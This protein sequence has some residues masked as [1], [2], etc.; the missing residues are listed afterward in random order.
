MVPRKYYQHVKKDPDKIKSIWK[1]LHTTTFL[2]II[3]NSLLSAYIF[4]EIL[5]MFNYRCI[6]HGQPIFDV[7]EARYMNETQNELIDLKPIMKNNNELNETKVNIT[8]NIKEMTVKEGNNETRSNNG[9]E[10]LYLSIFNTSD[11]SVNVTNDI[12]ENLKHSYLFNE[13]IWYKND[14]LYGKVDVRIRGSD[15]GSSTSCDLILFVPL[16]SLI[17]AAAFGALIVL[18]GRG[19]E[20]DRSWLMVYPVLIA[21]VIMVILYIISTISMK[22]GLENFCSKFQHFTGYFTCSAYMGYF[23]FHNQES[24]RDFWSNYTICYY[25]YIT[26]IFLWST[27][28]AVTILRLATMADFQFVTVSVN[29]TD[30]NTNEVRREKI[31]KALK[32]SGLRPAADLF[33]SEED[34]FVSEEN[35]AYTHV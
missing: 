28:L 20:S 1:V 31:Q 13:T 12:T 35:V 24:I 4:G 30:I 32:S 33:P 16:V 2:V 7:V 21:S 8:E 17:A 9:P 26:S 5:K 6:L 27:Q 3:L 23:S 11:E 29:T 34:M 14:S 10:L 18:F 25:S 15:Y 19:Q 22:Q